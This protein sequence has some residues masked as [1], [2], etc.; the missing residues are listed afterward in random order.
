[1]R[2]IFDTLR[3]VAAAIETHD[4][5]VCYDALR[6][7]DRIS[8]AVPPGSSVCVIGPNGCG[9]ST[10]LKALAGIVEPASGSL[11]VEGGRPAI[12]LQSTDVD[13][14]VPIS[15]RDTVAMARYATL[16][17]LG[18]FR[19]ADW[20][21]VDGA[22]R[23]LEVDDLADRQLHQLSGGQRQRVLVAQGLA[24][25]SPVLLLD[26][27]FTAVDVTSRALIVEVLDQ[28]RTAG[29]TTMISTHN[30]E[31]AQRCDLVLLLATQ[32][33][34]FGPPAEVL[35][36]DHLRAAFGGRFVRVG[37]TLLLDDPHHDH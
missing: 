11:A 31:D 1:M 2:I 25:S 6:A 16:G 12:V 7:L 10:L 33:V 18:R 32:S 37:E 9:K 17:L 28:E 20:A 24:Q 36:E 23:R 8:L 14:A 5:V 19:A 26:E 21:A 3:A 35:T 29:R 34:A 4:L 22:M 27:P 30:F 15:V 13:Q